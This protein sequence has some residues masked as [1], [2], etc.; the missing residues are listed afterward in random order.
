MVLV[1][2]L[3]TLFPPPGVRAQSDD[4]QAAAFNALRAASSVPVSGSVDAGSVRFLGFDVP[5]TGMTPTQQA[6][7]FLASYGAILGQTGVDQRLA[8]RSVRSEGPANIAL[9]RQ[10]YKGVPVFAGEVRVWV[11]TSASTG[12]AR[13]TAAGGALLPDL[14]LE[15]GLDTIPSISPETCIAAA[16]TYIER[17][18]AEPLADPK[19]MIFDGRL[20]G[21]AAGAHLVWAATFGDGDA[22][23]VL[24]DAHSGAIVFTRTFESDSLDLDLQWWHLGTL[25]DE[26]GLTGLGQSDPETTWA[27]WYI[28][29]V[30][31]IYDFDFGWR[32]TQGND[33]GLQVILHSFDADNAMFWHGLFGENIQVRT[34]WTSFDV[35]A[36]EFTHGVI[37]HTSDLIYQN[38]SGALN[39][40]YADAMATYMDTQDW[41]LGEDR[42]GFP[43]SYLR[44]FQW[45]PNANQPDKFSGLAGLTNNPIEA[46][47]Y[48]SVHYN[49]GILNKAHYLMA[50]GVAFNGR[51]GFTNIALGRSKMGRLAFTVMRALPAGAT[52]QD[53]R[54][55]SIFTAANAAKLNLFGFVPADVCAVKDAFAAVEIGPGD[56]NCD[57][58]DDNF[59]DP[60]G[61]FVP[62][63]GDNCPNVWNPNQA[64]VTND[65]V[66]DA[67]DLD[68]DN[69]GRPDSMD[70]CLLAKN[71]DQANNDGD[72][73]GDVC[74][75]DDDNDGWSD[76]N[77][78]CQ[79]DY[80]PSQIDGNNNGRGD[81]CDPDNDGDGVY[82]SGFPGDN[83]PL[84]YNPAQAD[85]DGD[86]MGDACDLCPTVADG[87]FNL[88]T[89]PPTPYE[90]DSDDDG[91]PDACDNDAFGVAS[92]HLNGSPYN[93]TQ[94]FQPN[95]FPVFGT[96]A[97]P[98]G[99][100]FRIPV[101]VCDPSGDPVPSQI[102]EIVFNDLDP[103][104]DVTLLD[105][106]GLG[107]EH[108]RPGPPDFNAR[109]VRVTADCARTYLLE[110]SL[111]A[112]FFGFD[113]FVVRTDLVGGS[114]PNPYVTPG[115][116]DP[117]PPP[118]AD[119]DRDGLP[120]SVDS[121]PTV[122][123]P[124]GTDTDADGMGDACDNCPLDFGSC[125]A[126]I[127][128][129]VDDDCDG[130]I[131]NGAAPGPVDVRLNPQPFP[132]GPELSWTA[133]PDTQSYDVVLADLGTLRDSGGDFTVATLGCLADDVR[134]TSLGELPTPVPDQ[135]FLIL[136]R[137]NNCAGPGTY[138]SGAP[139]Q[140]GSRDPGINAAPA[141][142]HP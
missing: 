140:V 79:F 18:G 4:P 55:Y 32:G 115:S 15:G 65:G 36:H 122:A 51:P 59:Q 90:P 110:F 75:P 109:G 133:I 76:V 5:A 127:C 14:A 7:N 81:A 53:A 91:V 24:C 129:G 98:A 93:P 121:C 56:F 116:S 31:N 61:D 123:D 96:L 60:D 99:S 117:P 26:N 118:I 42:F 111:G 39:E 132:P 17:P 37:H 85:T 45:P 11:E 25:G 95:G 22:R 94:M 135:A 120:D 23:Q 29:L 139:S 38:V 58:V 142:C 41:L 47:D 104:V 130:F 80:N 6:G 88:G 63:P 68:F 89:D 57:G 21:G 108:L 49:S 82:N 12:L 19:L 54:A 10:T 126:E 46:N 28:K 71:W 1:L 86:G 78:N 87:A 35:L 20:L 72:A 73:Q 92:L 3:F 113:D 33:N 43:K 83:C 124:T 9:F 77:D 84:T 40:G 8:L 64:D 44:D 119:L 103:A 138:D 16:Q 30:Y 74:D 107:L 52:F 128:N 67:C 131:D 27:W 106:D 134:E 13:V 50:T 48:G 125:C 34:G 105:D 66:G 114:T 102:S 100:R 69:D 137:G 2:A 112:G 97:G 70:N 62:F 141:T 101:P 136:V